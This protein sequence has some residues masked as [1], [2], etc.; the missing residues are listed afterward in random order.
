MLFLTVGCS[1]VE[2]S[3][4]PAIGATAEAQVRQKLEALTPRPTLQDDETP[5]LTRPPQ[6]A[7]LRPSPMPTLTNGEIFDLV[8][9]GIMSAEE[10]AAELSRRR[11]EDS[12][13]VTPTPVAT[14]AQL[15]AITSVP[16]RTP[17]SRGGAQWIIQ[18]EAVVHELVNQERVK[19]SLGRLAVDSALADVARRHSQ[20]MAR[21]TFFA[22]ENLIGQDSTDRADAAGYSCVNQ[23]YV[24]VGENI[25]QG[26]LFSAIMTSGSL[27]IKAYRHWD[28]PR[29]RDGPRHPEP[30][31]MVNEAFHHRPLGL[32]RLLH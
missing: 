2:P 13:A 7:T 22:H 30:L 19:A 6:T 31:L 29:Y 5:T 15:P 20:D 8:D 9:R 21:N 26:W 27:S 12:G 3:A 28:Q 24:G 10:A 23:G 1:T 16:T 11:R 32:G 14:L 25:F 18:L 17:E 4:T